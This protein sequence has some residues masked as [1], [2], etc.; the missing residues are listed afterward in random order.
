MS[1]NQNPDAVS[2]GREFAGH[3]KPSEPLMSGGHQPG[4]LVGNDAVPEFHAQTLPAGTAP[5]SKTFQPNPDLNN[6]KMYHQA[7][8]TLQGATS[9]DVHTGLGHPGQGQTSQEL[10]DGS[11][12]GQGLTGLA[13]NV[14][15]QQTGGSIETLK[16]DPTHAAQRNL[17]DV[18]TGQRGNTGGAPAQE[19]EPS[20]A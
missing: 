1:Q 2:D 5:A 9:G 7:S 12:K 8:D 14:K 17:D 4:K 3:V 6:Q 13:G 11:R 10:H 18:P 20:S 19:R 16:D 15:D